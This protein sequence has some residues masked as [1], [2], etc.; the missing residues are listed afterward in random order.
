MGRV[1][2]FVVSWFARQALAVKLIIVVVLGLLPVLAVALFFYASNLRKSIEDEW[3]AWLQGYAYHLAS[4]LDAN[5]GERQWDVQ[6]MAGS[7]LLNQNLQARL[8]QLIANSREKYSQMLVLD[9]NGTVLAAAAQDESGELLETRSLMGRNLGSESWFQSAKKLPT[10]EFHQLEPEIDRLQQQLEPG[11]HLGMRFS[12]PIRNGVGQVIG[13]WSNL[14]KWSDVENMVFALQERGEN[15]NSSINFVILNSLGVVLEHP[16]KSLIK[17]S[18]ITDSAA[19]NQKD[20]PEGFVVGRNY[21]SETPEKGMEGWYRSKNESGNL[22]WVFIASES[23]TD[24]EASVRQSIIEVLWICLAVLVVVVLVLTLAT[25]SVS[26]GLRQ[27]GQNAAGL[28]LGDLEQPLGSYAKDEFGR[29]AESFRTMMGYQQRMANAASAI[30]QGDL[31]QTV[32]PASDK[33]VLGQAFIG[34]TE[35]LTSLLETLQKGTVALSSASEQ[36]RVS[37]QTQASSVSGQFAAIAQT[38]ATVDQVQTTTEQALEYAVQTRESAK[39]IRQVVLLGVEATGQANQSMGDIKARVSD[40]AENI[41]ALSEQ[42]QAIGDIIA[43]VGKLSDQSN[44]LSLNAAIEAAR[45]G[46]HGKGFSV[47]A[48]EI[49]NLAEQSKAATLRVRE[50][51]S[52]IQSATN[53]AVMTTEQGI[54]VAEVGVESIARVSEVISHLSETIESAAQNAHLISASVQQHS[55]G[56]N[57]ISSAMQHLKQ[58]AETTLLASEQSK[59]AAQELAALASRLKA[60]TDGYVLPSNSHSEV[61]D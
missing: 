19:Q 45:A 24:V 46:E 61:S 1:V 49:R 30:R 39:S 20:K 9:N 26:R 29:F 6:F 8:E 47:V 18:T 40:I 28:A 52:Q 48:L 2:N 57:Q 11:D 56:M 41:L 3:G 27:L 58:N 12:A 7:A 38:S 50:L 22:G 36:M 16:Q 51:L 54:K 31:T 23:Y 55:V 44:L 13:V 17:Q 42:T 25:R 33:D 59:S 34:M 60:L 10:G 43:L 15:E 32:L 21:L 37:S 4:R 35:N 53:S 5:L 14:Y